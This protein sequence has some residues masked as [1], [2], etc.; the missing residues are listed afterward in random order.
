MEI[1]QHIKGVLLA[2]VSATVLLFAISF[3]VGSQILVNHD[4]IINADKDKV[5]NYVKQP[6]NFLNWIEGSE[7]IIA[8]P[9]A[10]GKGIQ[11]IGF[12]EKLHTFNFFV[13]ET[14]SGVEINYTRENELVAVFKIQVKQKAEGCIVVYEKIWNISD[15]PLTKLFSM[16]MDEDIE[17]GMQKE[18]MSL[19]K[20]IELK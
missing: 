4:I 15:N 8:K 19:K 16:S 20:I 7:G 12:N 14:A 18:L 5:F 17:V 9:T 10:N 6:E 3:F 13:S 1:K 2:I 11:Y